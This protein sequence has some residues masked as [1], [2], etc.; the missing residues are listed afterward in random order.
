MTT[1]ASSRS[2]AFV[3]VPC[4][5]GKLLRAKVDQ[6]GAEIQCWDCHQM[7]VVP[8]PNVPGQDDL[9]FR[10]GLESAFRWPT[11]GRVAAGTVAVTLALLVPG[12]GLAVAA[13]A[14]AVALVAVVG[15]TLDRTSRG[16]LAVEPLG[17]RAWLGLVATQGAVAFLAATGTVLSLWGLHAGSGQGHHGSLQTLVIFA[18]TWTVF[19]P[20]ALILFGRDRRSC[21][22]VRTGA[23]V[24]AHHPVLTFL[25]VLVV[26]ASVVAAE[27]ALVAETVWQETFPFL[28]LD[29]MPVLGNPE[30][31]WGIPYYN[32][33][34]FR[35]Y[36]VDRFLA[37]YREA[38]G[39]GYTLSGTLPAS[40]SLSTTHR[41]ST[42]AI[43]ASETGYLAL[44][45]ALSGLG[46]LI[47]LTGATIQAAWLGAMAAVDHRRVVS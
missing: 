33:V 16:R 25:A 41:L 21:L 29:T 30:L 46:V 20:V 11:F 45:A 10:V 37:S 14:L 38:L 44:R 6:I 3:P 12:G 27:L 22:G 17:R 2:T 13:V 23:R 34:D 19:P 39:R 9:A 43:N 32:G 7:V 28:V 42:H 24:L 15:H 8:C 47:F 26:P 31:I 4:R 40:L 36:P 1:M 35:N 5:C 18:A